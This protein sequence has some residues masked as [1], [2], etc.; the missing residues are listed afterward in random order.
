ME[1]TDDV[2]RLKHESHFETVVTPWTDL[3]DAKAVAYNT[4]WNT[5]SCNLGFVS[6]K[7]EVFLKLVEERIQIETDAKSKAQ[8]AGLMAAARLKA[9][10]EQP[11]KV[12]GNMKREAKLEVGTP[13][14][15]AKKPKPVVPVVV[16]D[17]IL[18]AKTSISNESEHINS[19]S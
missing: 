3:D 1:A 18:M 14:P 16:A 11:L 15:A 7:G 6:G 13:S 5:K 12:G 2:R 17:P 19:S 8:K 4:V 9:K 10:S